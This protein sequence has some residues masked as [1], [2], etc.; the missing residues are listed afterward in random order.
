MIYCLKDVRLFSGSHA[1]P[2]LLSIGGGGG[3]AP[4]EET[5]APIHRRRDAVLYAA[6][7][8]GVLMEVQTGQG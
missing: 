5:D 1:I 7:A 6:G 3:P 2:E 4:L 8:A